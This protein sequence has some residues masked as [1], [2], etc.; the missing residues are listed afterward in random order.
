MPPALLPFSRGF[1]FCAPAF[2]I[3]TGTGTAS[4]SAIT[5]R[6]ASTPDPVRLENSW[7]LAAIGAVPAHCC[8]RRREASACPREILS[9]FVS[10]ICTGRRRGA[11]HARIESARAV[12]GRE[13]AFET[14]YGDYRETGGVRFARSI[15]IGVRG[16]PQ[17]LRIT[18]ED[19]EVNPPLDESRFHRP[20]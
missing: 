17:R 15:E 10:R 7:A 5:A 1:L 12:R 8:T 20:R 11:N 3:G 2:S 19:V 9:A 14:T 13:L 16:R 4:Q 18:V 6:A